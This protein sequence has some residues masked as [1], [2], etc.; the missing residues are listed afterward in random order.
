MYTVYP[1]NPPSDPFRK[2]SESEKSEEAVVGA[3]AR[4]PDELSCASPFV[5]PSE[6]RFGADAP[7]YMNMQAGF[8]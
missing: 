1:P 3:I 2:D 8:H 6:A 5:V 7:T 4:T